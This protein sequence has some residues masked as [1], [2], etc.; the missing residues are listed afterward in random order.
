MVEFTLPDVQSWLPASP[1][2]IQRVGVRGV[3]KPVHVKRPNRE[4][5]TL[6]AVFEIFVDLPANQ[7]GVHM[8]RNLEVAGAIL[9]DTLRR[10][11]PD[12]EGVC[13][14]IA[15]ELLTRHE[16]ASS[17]EV[18]A[19]ADYFM[20]RPGLGGGKSVEHYRLIAEARAKRGE[21]T[22]KAIGVEV[23]GM[24]A[25][26]CAMETTRN[27]LAAENKGKAV[28][29]DFAPSLTHNQR[30]VATLMI[31][32]RDKDSVDAEKLIDIAEESLSSPTYELLKRK[33]EGELVLAAHRNP[34]FVEDVVRSMLDLTLERFPKLADDV[35]VVVRSEAEESIHKHNAYAEVVTTLGEV[36]RQRAL[37]GKKAKPA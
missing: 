33:A 4:S 19:V 24:T 28:I 22:R 17:S 10:D 21:G 3:K 31:E 12:L 8:S 36:R 34:K 20:E 26:P 18:R 11:V 32:S 35:S 7:K 14:R 23:V 15:S 5:T 2:E 30:N 25:C 9:D 16:Y 13:A 37:N 27:L 29:P 1:Y 6:T